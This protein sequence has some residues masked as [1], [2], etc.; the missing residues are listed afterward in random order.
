MTGRRF[1]LAGEDTE[2]A[3]EIGTL[4][5]TWSEAQ[6]DSIPEKIKAHEEEA[7]STMEQY[8]DILDNYII[9]HANCLQIVK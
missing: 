7:Y 4:L 9:S 1:E 6:R 3:R 8:L 5:E 2:L